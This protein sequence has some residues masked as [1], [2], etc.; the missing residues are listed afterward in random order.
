LIDI[1]WTVKNAGAGV[2]AGFWEDTVYLRKVGDPGAPT[3]S[4]G[5]YRYDGPLAA[6]IVYSRREQVRVPARTA[7]LYEAVVTTN[8]R[9]D[10]YEHGAGG[11]N[12]LVDDTAIPITVKPRPDLRVTEIV[13]PAQVDPGQTVTLEFVVANQGNAATTIPN[14]QDRVYLSLDPVVSSDDVLMGTLVNQSALEPNQQYRTQSESAIVPKRF[15]GTVYLIVQTDANNQME[16]WPNDGNNTRYTELY[17]VPQPLPDLVASAVVAPTQAIEGATIDVRFTITNLGPGET[18]V[19]SWTDTVW[20][21]RDKNRPHPGQGDVLLRSLSHTGPLVNQAG[22]D[23]VTTV[24]LPTGLVSGTYY[25]T[26]WTDPYAI[27]LEDTLAI[28]VNPDDPHEIDNN[29]YKARAI[30]I[31]ALSA[32]SPDLTV[33]EVLAQP[34]ARGGDQYT[35]QWSVYNEDKGDATGNWIDRVWLTNDPDGPVNTSNSLLLG[36]VPHSKLGDKEAYVESLTVTLAPS[37]LG[38]Y[39]VVVTDAL[40]QV[41]ETDEDNNRLA[42]VTQVTPV[43]ADLVVTDIQVPAGARSGEQATISFTVTNQGDSVWAGTNYWTD[44]VW[45]SADV[46]FRRDRASYFGSAVHSNAQP[47]QPGESY[48]VTVTGKLPEGIGGDFF[49]Y[50]HLDTHSDFSRV[51]ETAW[52]PAHVGTNSQRL[53]EF[54][55]W[56][57][58]DPFN[59][60]QAAGF[61]VAFYEPD[62][63]ISGLQLDPQAGTSGQAVQVTFTVTNEGT[64]ETRTNRWFDRVF[65]SRDASLDRFDTMIGQWQHDGILGIGESY[66]ATVS[67][68]LPDGI[69]GDFYLLVITDSP[70]GPGQEASDIGFGNKGVVFEDPYGLP[71]LD[72]VFES[73]RLL[74]RGRVLEYQDEGNNTASAMLPVTLAATPDLQVTQVAAP[75]RVRAGQP[76]DVTY[77]VQNL[78]GGTPP[79]QD[80]WDDLI[81]LSRDGF[82]DLRADRF[83][84]QYRRE[85]GLAAGG[86]YSV[87]RTFQAPSGFDDETEEYYVFVVTDPVRNS[88]IGRVFELGAETNND[89]R[90]PAPVIF[91][92]PPPTDLQV[93]RVDV[94]AAARSGEPVSVSWT[95]TNA[96]LTEAASGQWSDTLYLSADATWDIH[97]VP[98]GRRSFSGTLLP[99]QEYTLTLDTLLPP[100]A[101]GTYRVIVRTD[102]FNQVY[103]R[104]FDANNQRASAE[105]IQ[106][107]VDELQ[108]GVPHATTLS[109]GQTRLF[110]VA[111][112]LDQTLRVS[113]SSQVE[114]STNEL[115]LR[116]D[117]APTVAAFDA[118]YRGGLGGDLQAVIPTTQPGVYFVLVRGFQEP[119]DDTPVTLLAE[120]VPL[121]ITNVATDVGGD[122]RFVTTT[123]E[124][125]RFHEAAIVKL[126]RPGF[127]EYEPVNY[128]VIDA[129]K[130]IATFDFT[131]APHGLYDV[132]V[133]NPG[134]VQAV[135]P[136]RFLV[137]QAIEPDV[138]IGIGG[139]RAILAGDVGT[140]SVAL[141]SVSNLDTPYVFFQVGIPEMLT[142]QYVYGLPFVR[143]NSNVRGAPDG[144]EDVPWA[145]IDSSVNTAGRQSGTVQAPGYLFDHDANGFTGFSFNVS[146]Y[147]GLQELHDRAWDEVVSAVYAAF[148]DL[149]ADGALDSGPAGLDQI[150]PGLTDLYNQ[151]AAVPSECEIPFIPFRF[152]LVAAATAMT[153]DEFIAQALAEAETLRQAIIDDDSSVTPA[154][155]TLAADRADWGNLFLAALEQAGLLRDEDA[156]PPIRERERIIS[157]MATLS[158]GILIGPAGQQVITSGSLLDFF[159]QVRTWYG[160]NPSLMTD[161]EFYDPRSSD[162]QDGEIPVPALPDFEAY[163]LGLSR[164][165]HFEAFRVYVPWMPFEDRAAGL[166]ADFQINGPQP[167]DGDGFA[168]LDLSQY[169]DGDA[170][171]GLASITGP[172]TVDT[173]GWLP[174]AERL[175][176]SISFANSPAAS[177]FVQ[178]VRVVTPLDE[179]LDLFSFQ[180]GDI[181]VGRINVHIPAGRALFQGEFDFSEA[182]GFILRISAGVDQFAHEATWLL[183]AIDPLTGE[184]LQDPHRGLL[185]PNNAQGDGAAFVSYTILPDSDVVQT[186]SE[187]S[188]GS[189]VLFNNAPPED[190][191]VLS[192]SVDAAGPSTQLAVERVAGQADNYLVEWNVSDDPNGSGFKH[193]TLYVAVDGG[194]YRI[195]QRQLPDAA[196][197]L[198]Y[199]GQ[200]GH[201]YQFLALASDVAG[202]REAAGVGVTAEDDGSSV[203]LGTPLSVPDTTPPNFGI[204]PEPSPE[205]STNPLFIEA[206]QAVPAAGSAFSPAEFDQVLRP[207]VA[208]AFATGIE[209]SHADIGPM[210]IVEAPDGSLL[211]SGGPSR[212]FLYRFD[213]F[214]GEAFNPW[215]EV[216]YPIFNMAFDA[217]GRLWA[218]TGG[219]PLLQLDPDSGR[220]VEEFGDGVT[221][222]LAVEPGSGDLYMAAGAVWSGGVAGTAG[223][224]VVFD[225]DTETFTRFNRDLNLRVASLAFAPDGTLW[226]TTWPDRQQVVRFTDQRRA[227]LVL[228]FDAPVDSLA[229]GQAG[230]AL[231]GLLFVSHN[232]GANQH[233]GSELTMVDVATLRRVTLADGGTRGDVIITTSDGRVLISQS[234]QVDVLNPAAAPLVIAT[235]PPPGSIVALPLSHITVTFDQDMFIGQEDDDG[236]VINPAHYVLAGLATGPVVIQQ[237]FYVAQTHT[238][239]LIPPSLQPDEYTLTVSRSM[240]SVHGV[241]MQSDY[242]A[243]FTAVSDFSEYLDIEFTTSRSDRLNDTVSWDVTLT[244]R[245]DFDLLLPL[246][247]VLD[248]AQGYEGVP[249]GASGRAPDGRWFIDLTATLPDGQ[250][251]QPGETTTGRTLTIFNADDRRVE[252][253]SGA[254]G[255]PPLNERPVFDSEPMT[256]ATAGQ[257]YSYDAD[258]HD[259]DGP[260]VFFLLAAGPAGM[261]VDPLSGVF[262]WLPTANSPARAAVVLHAYDVRG[263]RAEQAFDIEVTGGN[264]APVVGDLPELIEGREGQ[265]LSLPLPVIDPD[266]DPL[267]V[268]A[269]A[270]PP[271]AALDPAALRL[272]WTPDFASAGTYENVTFHFS[273]GV[274]EVTAKVTLVIAPA[275][276]PP[277]L[278]PPADRTIREGD[279]LRFYLQGYDPDGDPVKFESYLL[280]PGAKLN[281]NTGLFDWTPTYYAEGVYEVPFTVT[282]GRE[283]AT[284]TATL[285]VI[286]ANGAPVFDDLSGFRVFEGQG[287]SFSA[288]AFDPDNPAYEPPYRNSQGDLVQLNIVPPSVTVSVTDLPPGAAFDPETTLFSWQ[289]DYDQAGTYFVTFTAT[290][291]G[292]GTGFPLAATT[293][294]SLTVENLNRAP[295]I[296]AIASQTVRRGEVLDLPV[297][298]TDPEGNPLTLT[299]ESGLP[300]FPLPSFVTF[301]DNGD[302][303]GRFRFAPGVGDRGDHPVVLRAADD[304]DGGGPWA[305]LTSSLTFLV[306]VESLNE[307]PQWDYIGDKVAV[308][309]EPFQLLLTARDNDQEPLQFARAGLPAA[310]TLTPGAVYGTAVLAWTPQAGDVGAYDASVT[311]TDTGNGGAAAVESDLGTFR[312]VVRTSNT[313]PNLPP[314][315][316]RAV[317]EG[318]LLQF[319]AG[320][321]D[322]DGDPLTYRGENLPAGATLDPASGE[323]RW[324]PGLHQAGT[325]SDVRIVAGDGH[326]SRFTT[327]TIAVNN[328]NQ[329]PRIVPRAPLFM[330]EGSDLL[331]QM[332]AGDADGDP[333][334]F[335]AANLPAG[336]QFDDQGSFSWRPGYEQAGD[337]VITFTATDPSG[338]SDSTDVTLRIEN[339]NRA[340]VLGTSHHAVRLG[341]TLRFFIDAS[342]PDLGTTLAYAAEELPLGASV[343]PATGEF[344]WTPGPGQA[345][346]YLIRLL[347]SD[348]QA[349]S[350]QVVVVRAAV[351]LPGPAVTVVLTPSFPTR[352]GDPVIVHAIADS[353]ADIASLQ[354]TLDGQPIALDAD[355]RAAI[356]TL[357]L[358]RHLVVATATDVDGLVGTASTVLK[359]RDPADTAAP[360]VDLAMPA[361]AAIEDGLIR[362]LVQDS[363]LDEWTLEM[364]RLGDTEFTAVANGHEPVDGTLAALDLTQLPNDF[365]VFR[366]TAR[367]IGRRLARAETVVELRSAEKFGYF[368]AETDLAVTLAGVPVTVTRAYDST[369]AEQQGKFG[370]GWRFLGRELDVR[371]NVL[372]TGYEAQGLYHPYEV[373]TRLYLS[374]PAGDELGFAFDPVRV[375]TPGP[376]Y[377]APAWDLMAGSAAGWTLSTPDLRLMKAGSRF[378]D[379]STAFPYNP[380]SPFFSGADFVL[381]GPDGTRY[382]VDAALGV[383]SITS[384]AGSTVYVG[385]SGLTATTGETIQFIYDGAGRVERMVAPDGGVTLYSYDAQGDL[386]AVRDL[387]T[388]DSRR[389][390]YD[391]AVPHRLISLPWT[392]RGPARRSCT[393]RGPSPTTAPIAGNLGAAI[394]FTGQSFPGTLAAGASRPIRLQHS[395][396]RG[397]LDAARRA[398]RPRRCARRRR[399]ACSRP[400][401]R[402]PA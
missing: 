341:Q 95:V 74:A 105:A 126:V 34:T 1:G 91:E 268:W 225:P 272:I 313:S 46:S 110:Q 380:H 118:A 128:E 119:A 2:A 130:I 60:V 140:Y 305:H 99:G 233:P 154:L 381:A 292:D 191:P 284:E 223:G 288:F 61:P 209:Q 65:L 16:E 145:E 132:T 85:G 371:D 316:N 47:L 374:T 219:G 172:Q 39:I 320:A 10:L 400:C 144:G 239:F 354:V 386:A 135:V 383:V 216:P 345:G 342:D 29:N 343:N 238:A 14:W 359:V 184:L 397:C 298:V 261:T 274:N 326:R 203:N 260:A 28:N 151:Q 40:N 133:I 169:L 317:D 205:P 230:T 387:A 391:L 324:T 50:V 353:L 311:V 13:A 177:Q 97:D 159:E 72:K 162:C 280:P 301:T 20:L 168:P 375:V 211:V 116:Y 24:T 295:E 366:L 147:P 200:A 102:I 396:Q 79:T 38:S 360:I 35:V 174:L 137:E 312:L 84:G 45:I 351:E 212:N 54:T 246:V 393:R 129:S 186:G 279:R 58:E 255:T 165:T 86:S 234:H 7:G 277:V 80:N 358:G 111:V 83:L 68:K 337:Y 103:E 150:H 398:V 335:S 19:D 325:H 143:F 156:I 338:L 306:T 257:V 310:A 179:D 319:F 5:S 390:G 142:N 385:D 109:T 253:T 71:S 221:M 382:G 363:N 226:A 376:V 195:W 173:Q 232:E 208:Q 215:A 15:R 321:T 157:L 330:R 350:S 352:P 6:G 160:N 377:Y 30:D 189:R 63:V 231:E 76:F 104:E 55:R 66:E 124:G 323:F 302:G 315:P 287:V 27:V 138:T 378:F 227:E 96:S 53:D 210:A 392:P 82:L 369:R 127:A 26:P 365:Y 123:I 21:T 372:P 282:N 222:A 4:L 52:W 379:L 37:A 334:V 286:N 218:T 247:L 289:P 278:V 283:R 44:Y 294:V 259:P 11:N 249:Q 328:V 332:E 112:P 3:I 155:T 357:S 88:P 229:F 8:Y 362:G 192:Q 242:A 90:S 307:P 115:F 78:G 361:L 271:G 318:Q 241:E 333:L 77:V 368:H 206:E 347:A 348:G 87:T 196:G 399:A 336:A 356:A 214:G 113:L 264:R 270:I 18:P 329:P 290:D 41:G 285:T 12:T 250:R 314:L 166:P 384:P 62:L 51:V 94:P 163:D 248:P 370:Q 197:S 395:R 100:A 92:L 202:N 256:A 275:D 176:Y 296:A 190:T 31:L 198:V 240:I 125:A 33:T 67:A 309:G 267:A 120:L 194:N 89:R 344:V 258:A 388:G 204:A 252:F 304:G 75:D 185:P 373:G 108:L 331:F 175:P 81:Y 69:G 224:I 167:V 106:V 148:P 281:P 236:S 300:G 164:P 101:P 56:A 364:K 340:P 402:S 48:D 73:Q 235:N 146:T 187:I 170:V 25:I 178:E 322:P 43:S 262:D 122:S 98:L 152:H 23:V 293:R 303:T 244:H 32:P 171:Q 349:T 153:R 394:S 266:G 269:D 243:T 263:G 64:R 181:S 134:G 297:T 49:V 149:A 141:Q 327:F 237:V 57:Y 59:N 199:E 136:Y 193:V 299:A 367:D 207:F 201:T 121:A 273:D 17:V 291:D 251:L 117:A 276:Q 182:L 213:R 131:G 161:V 93:A 265:S 9:N 355:G 183:Q 308:V 217:E 401:P 220:I 254:G 70:A 158:A 339:T 245:S 42:A 107:T 114:G 389:Y 228:Q 22:Y 346:E 139:P 36:E 188:A 180:L